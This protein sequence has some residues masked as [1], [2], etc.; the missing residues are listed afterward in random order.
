M[1]L[2]WCCQFLI[3]PVRPIIENGQGERLALI[4]DSLI[5]G[6]I[7]IVTYCKLLP[8]LVRFADIL[9]SAGIEKIDRGAIYYMPMLADT[10]IPI[11]V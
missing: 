5:T 10:V 2:G 9:N 6:I 11:R 7:K 4:C 1:V 3:Q 8:L